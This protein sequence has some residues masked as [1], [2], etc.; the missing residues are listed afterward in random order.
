MKKSINLAALVSGGKDS[1]YALYKE[2]MSG[3]K[4]SYIISVKSQS[5][6][7]YMYHFPN[8]DMVNLISQS[9]GIPL[10][11]VTT[12]GEKEKELIP[13]K[14]ELSRLDI[15]GVVSGAIAS[16]YQK[17]R[18]DQIAK[19][20]GIVSRAPLW[21]IDQTKLL[22]ELFENNF[23]VIIVATAAEGLGKEY[24]GMNL[25]DAREDLKK[26]ESKYGINV[27]GEGGEYETL[28][29]NCPLFKYPIKILDAEK[30]WD[31]VRGFYNIKKASLKV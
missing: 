23:D 13:L 4:I 18:I 1:V 8:L 31:K 26:L 15:D 30:V 21:G 9:I 2:L 24:L 25:A 29:L 27:A 19:E 11:T 10:L 6:D 17:S 22:D 28:V 5:P 7:S 12:T 20:L 16:S 14:N 3:N